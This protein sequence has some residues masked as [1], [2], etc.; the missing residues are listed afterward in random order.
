MARAATAVQTASPFLHCTIVPV[1]RY[2][3]PYVT[4]LERVWTVPMLL[5]RREAWACLA[6]A[7]GLLVDPK[8]ASAKQETSSTRV[9][10]GPFSG[11]SDAEVDALDAKS[12]DPTAVT[13]SLPSGARVY[14]LVEGV[15]RTPVKGDRVYVHYKVWGEG[16]RVGRAAD[17]SFADGVHL[18]WANPNSLSPVTLANNQSTLSFRLSR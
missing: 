16:F 17:Y 9:T 14:E 10:W 15:G 12:R 7:C 18:R 4:R 5:S 3:S 6:A 13:Y 2:H 8:A 1:Y 11:L